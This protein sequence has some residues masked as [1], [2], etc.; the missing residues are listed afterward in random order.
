MSGDDE[1][2]I[3]QILDSNDSEALVEL[4]ERHTGLFLKT[5]E[6]YLPFSESSSY[7]EDFVG[8]K[9]NVVYE[10]AQTF[11]KEKGV[12]FS[13]WFGNL[14]RYKCLTERTK[15][16]QEPNKIEFDSGMGGESYLTP[17]KYLFLKSES[18]N[19]LKKI[20]EKFGNHTYNIIYDI[21]F[22]GESGTGQTFSQVAEKYGVRHQA[23]HARHK[24][25]LKYLKNEN[26]S[27]CPNQ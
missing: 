5:V 25:V 9:L 8:D 10:A 16:S 1:I 17:D 21:Y 19:F 7:L 20:K 27:R 14:T 15:L 2:L 24:K 11:K 12:K 22:G 13:T 6:K 4:S 3:E 23:I 26:T 18:E